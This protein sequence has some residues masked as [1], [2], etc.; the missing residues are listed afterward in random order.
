MMYRN[1]CFYSN[2]DGG[3]DMCRYE[4]H[5]EMIGRLR[6][7]E[8]RYGRQGLAKV[9]SIGKSVSGRDLVY[10]KISRNATGPRS[11]TEPMFK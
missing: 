7:L 10:I 2:V 8:N 11:K 1:S 5:E 4:S 6:N 9:G 3:I